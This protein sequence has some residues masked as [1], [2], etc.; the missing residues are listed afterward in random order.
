M[1]NNK[2]GEQERRTRGR[3]EGNDFEEQLQHRAHNLSAVEA[4]S[5]KDAEKLSSLERG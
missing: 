4:D 3:A 2:R 5:L 1:K